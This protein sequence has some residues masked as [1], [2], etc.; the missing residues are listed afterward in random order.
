MA[1]PT[2]DSLLA[3]RQDYT[4]SSG[5]E[6]EKKKLMVTAI[7]TSATWAIKSPSRSTWCGPTTKKEKQ[8]LISM[9]SSHANHKYFIHRHNLYN[10]YKFKPTRFIQYLQTLTHKTLP[11]ELYTIL[12]FV[13]CL[14]RSATLQAHG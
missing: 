14:L 6:E 13:F 4:S 2:G 1:T 12:F 9:V 10:I 5:Q 8:S 3:Q 7:H 11:E